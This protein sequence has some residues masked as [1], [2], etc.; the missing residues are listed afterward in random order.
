MSVLAYARVE[1]EGLQVPGVDADDREAEAQRAAKIVLVVDLAQDLH[2]EVLGGLL[3]VGREL[4]GGDRHDDEDR[5][6]TVT[7]GLV[8]LPGADVEVLGEER[9]ADL[10]PDALEIDQRAAEVTGAGQ[11]RDRTGSRG[12]V[13]LGHRHRVGIG[14]DRRRAT[15]SAA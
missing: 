12:L 15:A 2:V 5:I 13:R 9:D 7:A 8:H 1:L 6:G 3:E 4:V 14:R 11:H 10:L